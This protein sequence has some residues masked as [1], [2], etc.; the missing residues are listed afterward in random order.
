MLLGERLK[1]PMVHAF[2]GKEHIEWDNPYDVGM[3]GLVGFSS[4]Y[5]AMNDCD[6]LLMLGTEFLSRQF[7]PK[8]A[9][10]AQI[11]IRPENLGR[12]T[13]ITMGLVGDVAATLDDLLPLLKPK[14]DRADLDTEVS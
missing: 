7:F 8:D 5:Y 13:P 12:R 10:I 2:R 3:T 4:G 6:A 11:D 9:K 14:N 1:A